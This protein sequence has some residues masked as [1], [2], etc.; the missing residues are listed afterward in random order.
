MRLTCCVYR[1]L[2]PFTACTVLRYW[3]AG[4]T[5]PGTQL[6]TTYG[7]ARGHTQASCPRANSGMHV[8]CTAVRSNQIAA[9]Q[10]CPLFVTCAHTHP[11]PA[12]SL[13]DGVTCTHKVSC[14]YVRLCDYR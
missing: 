7:T 3:L 11:V 5:E 9:T 1:P 13:R 14:N 2:Q 12:V 8:Y 6:Y 10:D 4:P